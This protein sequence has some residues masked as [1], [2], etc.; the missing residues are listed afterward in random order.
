MQAFFFAA[1]L[2]WRKAL[3]DQAST[4]RR[5]AK[6]TFLYFQ[7]Q[8]ARHA[9]AA[10]IEDPSG[11]TEE[12]RLRYGKASLKPFFG[13]TN[14]ALPLEFYAWPGP[15]Q[16][17][18]WLFSAVDARDQRRRQGIASTGGESQVKVLAVRK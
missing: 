15:F 4:A 12:V 3:F 8:F 2:L 9:K 5:L 16:T 17:Q 1:A 10:F 14:N 6:Q 11:R 18:L 13:C 7:V